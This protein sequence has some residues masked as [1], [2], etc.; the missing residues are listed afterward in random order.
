MLL[1]NGAVF[2]NIY[3]IAAKIEVRTPS[4]LDTPELQIMPSLSVSLRFSFVDVG[5][6]IIEKQRNDSS[7]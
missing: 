6:K 5:Y 1:R 2:I 7:V 3:G 4:W